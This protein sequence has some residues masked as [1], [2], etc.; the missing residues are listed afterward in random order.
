M[1]KTKVVIAGL[2]GISQIAHLPIIS[3]LSDVEI[4][5]VCDT[6]KGKSKFVA[7]KYKV[8]KYYTDYEKML[9]EIESDCMV[10]ATP[11]STHKDVAIAGLEAGLKVLV[12][13]PLARNS[14]EAQKIVDARKKG[15]NQLMVGMNNRFRPDFMMQRSFV[16]TGEL[17]EIFY[18]RAGFV[19]KRST[20]EK[21][22]LDPAQS[23]GG[24]FIDL[25]IVVLDIAQW[26]LKFAKVKSVSAVNYF[27][28]FKSVEDTSLVLIKFVNGATVS[29]E[30][31]WT[32]HREN[33][34]FYCNVFG[35]EGSS[36]VNPLR[37]YKRMHG[38]LVNVTP[39]KLEKPANMF[40]RSY[41]YELQHF[42]NSLKPDADVISNGEEALARQNVT[43]SIYKSAKTG[44]EI[45][46]K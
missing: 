39:V 41:E 37:I 14:A 16:S 33:D 28:K 20:V 23:G 12:E 32:L 22:A 40:I 25:G 17:G 24:V 1:N 46:L 3:K 2:G 34:V 7:E 42:F 9:N 21:W 18:I 44:K 38:T 13:K 27:H 35:T 31:S 36:S 29:L 6:D 8:K 11:T 45:F 30:S 4:A 5:A 19:R 15:K 43:D 26:L 10:V